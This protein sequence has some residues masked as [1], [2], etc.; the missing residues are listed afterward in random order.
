MATTITTREQT[1]TEAGS[2]ITTHTT[3]SFTIPADNM[4]VMTV[5]QIGDTT[6]TGTPTV[7]TGLGTWT[8][9]AQNLTVANAG[10]GLSVRK[11]VWYLMPS[12]EQT[13]TIVITSSGGSCY[14]FQTSIVTMDNITTA[15]SPRGASSLIANDGGTADTPATTLALTLSAR[16]GTSNVLVGS[17]ASLENGTADEIGFDGS[18]T[19]YGTIVGV[20]NAQMGS[21]MGWIIADD[22]TPS[23]T[24][25]T[26]ADLA[27]SIYEFENNEG[28]G[29][30][31]A[32]SLAGPGGLAG[33]GGLAGNHGGIAG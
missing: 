32:A 33:S 21:D 24:V 27:F 18:Y 16:G 9:L 14:T 8:I 19:E 31:V 12:T 25:A 5:A 23:I 10:I 17:A 28:G 6:P 1:Q 11:T 15:G 13:G 2:P 26:A 3:A 20:T 22:T 4:A 7:S 29:S 30:L